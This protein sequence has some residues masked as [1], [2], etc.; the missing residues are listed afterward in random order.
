MRAHVTPRELSEMGQFR[1]SVTIAGEM[2]HGLLSVNG[3][4]YGRGWLS[5]TRVSRPKQH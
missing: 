4:S 2:N 3:K 5:E 1:P